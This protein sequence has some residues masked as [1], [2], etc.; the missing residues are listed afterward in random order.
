M[1]KNFGSL[2]LACVL[3][4]SVTAASVYAQSGSTTRSSAPVPQD[5]TA[6]NTRSTYSGYEPF[7]VDDGRNEKLKS[8][9]TKLVGK[10]KAGKLYTSPNSQFSPQ[11]S[12]NLSKTAKIA[13][14][15]GIAVVVIGLIILHGIRNIHCESRCV[16]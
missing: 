11:H 8:D 3:I 5:A 15:A 1:K 9:M 16:I 12:N 10:A 2:T 6:A 4:F 13:I 7:R 14:I